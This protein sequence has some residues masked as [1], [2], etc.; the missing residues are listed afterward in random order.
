MCF[1][2]KPDSGQE[3]LLL[4][5]HLKTGSKPDTLMAVRTAPLQMATLFPEN[6]LKQA[7]EDIA[8]YEDRGHSILSNMKG[9]YN[10]YECP[11]KSSDS[12]RTD[13]LAGKKNLLVRGKGVKARPPTNQSYK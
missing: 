8:S 7:K 13:R 9:Q 2:G 11:D 12:K 5:T 6:A 10:P 4:I 1:Y 3:R